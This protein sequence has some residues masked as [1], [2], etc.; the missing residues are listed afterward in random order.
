MRAILALI[1]ALLVGCEDR[2]SQHVV[3][4]ETAPQFQVFD[5]ATA[6]AALSKPLVEAKRRH[7][8]RLVRSS[9]SS[10]PPDQPPGKV[11]DLVYYKA[12]VGELAAYLTKDPGDGIKYPAIVWI[13]GGDTNSISDVWSPRPRRNDQSVRAFRDAGI[14]MMFP[15]QRGGNNNPGR[16]E[17]F[18][19]EV[20]DILAATDYLASLPYVDPN[21]IYLGGHSTGGTLAMLIG[22]SSDR[23]SAVFSLG[24]VAT[25]A[26]Y[27]GEFVFCDPEDKQ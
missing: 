14:V 17:G 13:K 3:P 26:Q 11:F 6:P 15:S 16:R 18:Y 7:A 21:R 10:G 12:P 23:Y 22:A 2:S 9:A 19:G 8:T 4:S 24:P 25:A 1:P 5:G 27:G 20:A